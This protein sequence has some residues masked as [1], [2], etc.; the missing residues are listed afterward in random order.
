MPIITTSSR[1][2]IVIPKDIRKR[3]NI[4]P[5]KKLLIKAEKNQ[6]IITPLPDDPVEYFCG[7]FKDK[8]SLTKALLNER[9]KERNHES[10]KLSMKYE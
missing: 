10:K 3:L 1:G 9:R 7:F 6:A 5:G 8:S 4:F 2:Q